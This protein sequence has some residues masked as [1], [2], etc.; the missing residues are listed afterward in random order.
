MEINEDNLYNQINLMRLA[1]DSNDGKT[2]IDTYNNI[3]KTN[4]VTSKLFK[5]LL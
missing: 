4:Y 1:L 2:F 5:P 3:S